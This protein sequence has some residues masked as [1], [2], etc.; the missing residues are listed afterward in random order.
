MLC[1]GGL[2][3][4]ILAA[5][6]ASRGATVYP[7]YVACGL[8]WEDVERRILAEF[9]ASCRLEHLHP[10]VVLEVPVR[11][12]YG[13]HWSTDPLLPVPGADT[14]PD[15]VHLP[16][17]NLLLLSKAAL[18]CALANVPTLV[19]APLAGN[20]FSDASDPFFIRFEQAARIA[21]SH[22][23]FVLCPVRSVSKSRLIREGTRWPLH[24]TMSCISPQDE[25]HCG[26][27]NKCQERR[28]AFL[29][30]GV[31]DPTRYAMTR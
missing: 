24:L 14:E 27:C 13:R 8:R 4:S 6:Y 29:E 2:D 25:L 21:L 1:S 9:C 12:V 7:L 26:V 30:A 16:G 17:R 22:S 15:A 20:P 11:D 5:E 31:P 10:P 3:S 19:V 18:W 28:D 23:L